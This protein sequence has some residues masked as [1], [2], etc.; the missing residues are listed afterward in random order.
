MKYMR[1]IQEFQQ[2]KLATINIDITITIN[3][4]IRNKCISN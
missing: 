4:Q 3:M 2:D 1:I